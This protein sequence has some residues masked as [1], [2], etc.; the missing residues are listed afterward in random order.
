VKGKKKLLIILAAALLIGGG[1]GG[2]Y[3]F[4]LAPKPAKASKKDVPK[5]NGTLFTLQPDFVVNLAG[6]H[7]GKVTVALLLEQPPVLDPTASDPT[8]IQD[9]A[10]RSTITDALTGLPTSKLVN[11]PARDHLLTALDKD[12]NRATDTKVARVLFTDVV[13]Q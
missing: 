11:R 12:L 10:I 1:G 5:I 4:V 6:G 9:A 8:L 2:G 13:V 3:F 7:Y